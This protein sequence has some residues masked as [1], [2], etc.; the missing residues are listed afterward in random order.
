MP[1]VRMRERALRFRKEQCGRGP[2]F[3]KSEKR[4]VFSLNFQSSGAVFQAKQEGDI[5]YVLIVFFFPTEKT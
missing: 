3:E 5:V 1:F 4:C 2:V